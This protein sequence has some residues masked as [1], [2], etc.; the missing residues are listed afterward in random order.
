MKT[1]ADYRVNAIV[2][3][4]LEIDGEEVID[5]QMQPLGKGLGVGVALCR[6]ED[7]SVG[8]VRDILG[9]ASQSLTRLLTR[10]SDIEVDPGDLENIDKEEPRSQGDWP[11]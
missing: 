3:I 8:D 10:D 1:I 11:F 4:K 2:T 6:W 9:Y 7:F 5:I